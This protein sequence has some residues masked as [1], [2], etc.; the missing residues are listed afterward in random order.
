[1]A[2]VSDPPS[3]NAGASRAGRA[4]IGS[5]LFFVAGPGVV[6]GVVPWVLTRWRWRRLASGW[7]PLRGVGALLLG[8]G[9]AVLAHAFAR[10]V[11]EGMGTPAPAAPP[12]RLVVGG[13][14][15]Y[16][17][18]PMYVAI[19]AAIVGPALILGQPVLLL[20]GGALWLFAA[21]VV[22]WVEEPRLRRRFGA[23]YD[24]YRQAAPAW[25]PRLR[26]SPSSPPLRVRCGLAK[27]R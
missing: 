12:Q 8:A 9:L 2:A 17:R 15:R 21:A 5:A 18:N 1:L 20:Y 6:V 16:V 13:A 24:A 3:D 7:A 22:R 19:I 25:L 10:F 11:V 14:Y 27:M 4:A 26:T 23:D